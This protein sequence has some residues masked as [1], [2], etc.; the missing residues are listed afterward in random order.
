MSELLSSLAPGVVCTIVV[1]RVHPFGLDQGSSLSADRS[2]RRAAELLESWKLEPS[3]LVHGDKVGAGGQADVYVGRWQVS[4][5]TS[6]YRPTR[7]LRPYT[8]PPS[9][10]SSV[11]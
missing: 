3:E 6:A 4:S 10:R 9:A 1:T 11:L 8:C 7:N 5:C 2:M